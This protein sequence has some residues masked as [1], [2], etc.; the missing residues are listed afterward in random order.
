MNF[1]MHI[2]CFSLAN[3]VEQTTICVKKDFFY[4]TFLLWLLPCNGHCYAKPFLYM[5][6]VTHFNI[7]I[8]QSF[9]PFMT[10]AVII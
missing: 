4:M 6:V 9:N 5:I 7:I 8:A 10:E 3:A 1:T 2:T